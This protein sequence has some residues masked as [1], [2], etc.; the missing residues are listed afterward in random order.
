MKQQGMILIAVLL[1]LLMIELIVMSQ[2]QLIQIH[3]KNLNAIIEDH[4]VLYR[5]EQV[6]ASL[7]NSQNAACI[8]PFSDTVKQEHKGCLL[9]LNQHHYYYR[10]EDLGSFACIQL[11]E[12]G[13]IF[14]TKHWRLTVTEG[15]AHI[16][17]QTRY[18]EQIPLKACK[19]SIQMLT[20]KKM[21]WNW[22]D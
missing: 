11:Q 4:E 8:T 1:V 21:S 14:S 20:N 13:R 5:L 2:M 9:S 6:V 16:S 3:I 10:W 7:E 17:L 18:A 12:R 22:V 19:G 15:D